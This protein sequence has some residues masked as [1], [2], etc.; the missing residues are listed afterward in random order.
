MGNQAFRDGLLGPCFAGDSR[1][2]GSPFGATCCGPEAE[3]LERERRELAEAVAE[4]RKQSK[5]DVATKP[6][7][8]KSSKKRKLVRR[9]RTGAPPIHSSKRKLVGGRASESSDASSLDEDGE[10]AGYPSAKRVKSSS[11]SKSPAQQRSQRDLLAP[12]EQDDSGDDES[13]LF[14]RFGVR[15]HVFLV[16]CL[17]ILWKYLDE[18]ALLTVFFL[19]V[20]VGG[21]RFY[22]RLLVVRVRVVN[23]FRRFRLKK[24]WT[25]L[26][27]K[28][29]SLLFLRG[30]K[31]GDGKDKKDLK[32]VG[33]N[34]G[35]FFRFSTSS[36]GTT[37]QR[38]PSGQFH[39]ADSLYVRKRSLGETGASPERPSAATSSPSSSAK[40]QKPLQSQQSSSSSLLST[41]RSLLP[42]LTIT[43]ADEEVVR[44]SGMSAAGDDVE[45]VEDVP[46]SLS[47]AK[48]SSISSLGHIFN[49]NIGGRSIDT[50]AAS[51]SSSPS[52]AALIDRRVSRM[53]YLRKES[54]L[55]RHGQKSI[56]PVMMPPSSPSSSRIG[57][58]VVEREQRAPT[59][60]KTSASGGVI[61]M[62]WDWVFDDTKGSG[63]GAIIPSTP[64]SSRSRLSRT[65][66]SSRRKKRSQRKDSS[67]STDSDE[68]ATSS[69]GDESDLEFDTTY[70]RKKQ[71]KKGATSARQ[72]RRSS[73]AS[74]TTKDKAAKMNPTKAATFRQERQPDNSTSSATSSSS[75][76]D[77]ADGAGGSP[78]IIDRDDTVFDP[79]KASTAR[80]GVLF[81]DENGKEVEKNSST[82]IPMPSPHLPIDVCVVMKNYDWGLRY[83][84]N[85]DPI[86]KCLDLDQPLTFHWFGMKERIFQKLL[87]TPRTK[88]AAEDEDDDNDDETATADVDQQMDQQS[89]SSSSSQSTPALKKR[90]R[91]LDAGGAAVATARLGGVQPVQKENSYEVREDCV[92]AS[93]ATDVLNLNKQGVPTD[94][95]SYDAD[96]LDNQCALQV[97]LNV[98]KDQQV[99][100]LVPL[101]AGRDQPQFTEADY[102]SG[103]VNPRVLYLEK[104]KVGFPSESISHVWVDLDWYFGLPNILSIKINM[105]ANAHRVWSS[106]ERKR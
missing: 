90:K 15:L 77:D 61:N 94:T 72:R 28:T 2:E 102:L 22:E 69:S 54:F 93:H 73:A 32:K 26:K 79:L 19:F 92:V 27:K 74:S 95:F 80:R 8:P 105:Y 35:S 31:K 46:P 59:P 81:V 5:K 33:A 65:P 37:P 97:R 16:F 48:N 82:I 100:F 9:Q 91:Q 85:F 51:P 89:S 25:K 10:D 106:E 45:Q 66:T 4:S 29:K 104:E 86:T 30:G 101:R 39:N 17:L 41:K 43:G 1:K 87:V 76:A 103:R 23:Y 13:F 50:I 55:V 60:S 14:T 12:G 40:S 49:N 68:D 36:S 38:R 83:I 63:P 88:A 3:Q 64:S 11:K 99:V 75:S 98:I 52:A 47:R 58:V 34:S 24:Q 18:S 62:L 67:D 21:F 7:S 71:T 6:G 42:A 44:Y 70:A 78:G 96:L 20:G 57:S 53:P 56:P 84:M